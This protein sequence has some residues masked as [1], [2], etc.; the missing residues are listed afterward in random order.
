M[1]HRDSVGT[2]VYTPLSQS[3]ITPPISPP[4]QFRMA[5]TAIEVMHKNKCSDQQC[6]NYDADCGSAP[7]PDRNALV[8]FNRKKAQHEMFQ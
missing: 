8:E 5:S 4:P 2:N 1:N 6:S 7:D 3:P